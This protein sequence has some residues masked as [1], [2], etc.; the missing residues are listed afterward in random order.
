MMLWLILVLTLMWQNNSR[1][2]VFCPGPYCDYE[3]GFTVERWAPNWAAEMPGYPLEP[4][5]S[6][7]LPPNITTWDDVNVFP[8]VTYCYSLFAYNQRGSSAKSNTACSGGLAKVIPSA[9]AGFS[10]ALTIP[11][12]IITIPQDLTA[13]VT[14]KSIELTWST[15]TD[16]Q[17]KYLTVRVSVNGA[18]YTLILDSKTFP[19]TSTFTHAS[20][21]PGTYKYQ[22]RVWDQQDKFL[23]ETNESGVVTI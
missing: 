8:N 16:P 6:W 10:L 11:G 7:I 20:L 2:P 9:L 15:I 3:D 19:P 18:G 22:L 4:V 5:R 21:G 17:V 14:A 13:K 1:D 12:A 23:G